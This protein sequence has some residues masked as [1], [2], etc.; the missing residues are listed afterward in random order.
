MS[1]TITQGQQKVFKLNIR[2]SDGAPYDL[3]NF[4][5]YTVCLPLNSG[6]LDITEVANANGSVVALSGNAEAGTLEVTVN[7]NDTATLKTGER[8]DI[9]VK[10]N[11]AGDTNP[12]PLAG[13]GLLNVKADPCA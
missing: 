7:F 5:K 2:T 3:T 13:E 9:G 4:T 8:Q 11:N 10:I 1:V 12:Q 6:N